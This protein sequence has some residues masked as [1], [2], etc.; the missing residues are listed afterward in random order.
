[1]TSTC[2]SSDASS[3]SATLRPTTLYVPGSDATL[4]YLTSDEDDIE[5]DDVIV[6]ARE[7]RASPA[8]ES[9]LAASSPVAGSSPVLPSNGSRRKLI[10]PDNALVRKFSA[11]GSVTIEIVALLTALP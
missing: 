5:C 3:T 4:S 9:P 7:S 6:T 8:G 1:M 2:Q 11:S 10:V